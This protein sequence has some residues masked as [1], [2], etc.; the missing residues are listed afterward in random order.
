MHEAQLKAAGIK[1]ASTESDRAG[2]PQTMEAPMTNM[3]F[4]PPVPTPPI[5]T[6]QLTPPALAPLC[7]AHYAW[8]R[9]K[10][11]EGFVPKP[12][13]CAPS[14]DFTWRLPLGSHVGA[15]CDTGTT[16]FCQE[17]PTFVK[18]SICG[19]DKVQAPLVVP[20]WRLGVVKVLDCEQTLCTRY[21]PEDWI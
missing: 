9:R 10:E 16:Q 19:E 14:Q 8:K 20:A 13:S 5:P 3:S 21:H 12:N 6:L 4:M 11:G 7:E 17:P 18:G 2:Q 15:G 1:Q